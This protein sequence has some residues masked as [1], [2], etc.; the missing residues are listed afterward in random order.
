MDRRPWT[1]AP[2]ATLAPQ[3]DLRRLGLQAGDELR[4]LA[5][6]LRRLVVGEQLAEI[7]G[8]IV[9]HRPDGSGET[10]QI[11]TEQISRNKRR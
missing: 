7:D 5:V 2:W 4:E 11:A 10:E 8:G 9:G 3:P 6:D 1:V